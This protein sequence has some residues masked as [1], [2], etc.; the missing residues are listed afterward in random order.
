MPP[1]FENYAV[2]SEILWEEYGNNDTKTLGC[3]DEEK[4]PICECDIYL[5]YDKDKFNGHQSSLGF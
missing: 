4:K 5:I 2:L 3:R 1:K